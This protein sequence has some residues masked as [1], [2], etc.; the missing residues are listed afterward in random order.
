MRDVQVGSRVVGLTGF[1][2]GADGGSTHTGSGAAA[3]V[4]FALSLADGQEKEA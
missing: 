4:C 2:W 1:V 3:A